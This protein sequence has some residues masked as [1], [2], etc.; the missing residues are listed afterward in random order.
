MS[1]FCFRIMSSRRSSGPSYRGSVIFSSS[2]ISDLHRFP[3]KSH[4]FAGCDFRLFRSFCKNS[5]TSP[6]GL[7]QFLPSFVDRAQSSSADCQIATSC[8]RCSLFPRSD[9]LGPPRQFYFRWKTPCGSRQPDRHPDCP[10]PFAACGQDRSPYCAASASRLRAFPS[11]R[12][13][14]RSSC[15]SSG[16]RCR[17]ALAPLV[18]NACG[19]GKIGENK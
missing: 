13:H 14:C 12:S 1:S 18:S 17:A 5:D 8:I 10:D 7:L 2:V 11:V 16:R 19:S 6:F 9:N 4:G 15:S 3:H